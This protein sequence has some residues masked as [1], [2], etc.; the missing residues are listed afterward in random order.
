VLLTQT[1]AVSTPSVI[2]SPLPARVEQEERTTLWIVAAGLVALILKIIIAS[3]TLGTNDVV[4][5]YEFAKSLQQH[6]LQWTYENDLSFNHP[7]LTALYL[8]A[9]YYLDHKLFFREHGLLFPFLL[10]LP[11]ILADLVTLLALLWVVRTDR[12]IR[13]PAWG[14]LLFALSPVSVMIS[15]FHGNTDSVM[16]MFLVLATI[17]TVR[18]KP[19]LAG[20]FLAFGWQVKVVAL[21]LFPIFF[22]FWHR[23]RATIRFLFPLSIVSIVLSLEPITQFPLLFFRNV[24]AYGSYWGIW[25]ITYWLRLTGLPQFGVVGFTN[26]PL[27]ESVVVSILKLFIV[28]AV[29]VVSWRCRNGDEH[30]F[31]HGLAC[32]WILFFVFSPGVCVQ[33]MIW[34]APFVLLFSAPFYGWLT[35]TSSL[36]IFFFYNV[37]A[38]GLPWYVAISTNQ[39]NTIWTPWTIMPWGT[40]LAGLIWLWKNE[41]EESPHLRFPAS[42]D[43]V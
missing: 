42:P 43:E 31:L 2:T 8:R 19:V 24:L 11:G 28:A 38:H 1:S 10:R 18:N 41:Q 29:L 33:Y 7:P 32:I 39:L 14:L 34:L 16:V 6:G 13:I 40:L 23:R 35:V 12:R 25:G 21:L 27:L 30:V 5:F 4:T 22:L 20:L 37:T 15:G 9:I 26:L 17:S 36:F 3:N